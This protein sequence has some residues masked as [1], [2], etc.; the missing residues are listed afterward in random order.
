MQSVCCVAVSPVRSAPS[1]K[2]EMVSQLLFG[3]MISILEKG[4]DQWVKIRCQYDEYEGWVTA[5]HLAEPPYQSAQVHITADWNNDILFNDQ[6]MHLSF[7]SDLRG[8]VNGRAEWGKYNWTFKGNHLD[9]RQNKRTEKNI[10]KACFL[11]INTPYL[12]GG[13]SVF[14][15]DCSG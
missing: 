4:E 14:G 7:G 13:R 8:L 6:P 9:P 10:Q 12:W 3:E 15:I 1:H 5:H 11:F 2:S